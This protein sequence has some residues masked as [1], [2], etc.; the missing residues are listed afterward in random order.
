MNFEDGASHTGEEVPKSKVRKFWDGNAAPAEEL[1]TDPLLP[2]SS[3]T[4][5][6][7]LQVG[8]CMHN[9]VY[10]IPIIVKD[11]LIQKTL[12]LF[13]WKSLQRMVVN[14]YKTIVEKAQTKYP[15]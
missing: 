9:Q 3:D 12:L 2:G 15:C 11:L 1:G 13:S 14:I 6:A 5:D 8:Q 10:P 7:K 4:N